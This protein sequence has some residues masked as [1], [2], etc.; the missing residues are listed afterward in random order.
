MPLTG[1]ITDFIPFLT[2]SPGERAVI[3]HKYLTEFRK[4]VA[5]PISL[6]DDDTKDV[7]VGNIELDISKDY[8]LCRVIAKSYDR[9]LGARSIVQG[10]DQMIT[11]KVLDH[12]IWEIEEALRE[13]QGIARYCAEVD[14]DDA[15]G[16]CYIP[17]L[18]EH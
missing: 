9:Q 5:K 12:Y 2:F 18:E 15:V 10:V 13:E 4:K 6:S 3:A 1:R 14:V 17:V 7:L 16:I 8:S 11:S